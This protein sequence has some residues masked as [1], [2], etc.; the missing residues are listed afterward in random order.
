MPSLLLAQAYQRSYYGV[1]ILDGIVLHFYCINILRRCVKNVANK[2]AADG[3]LMRVALTPAE[4]TL[5]LAYHEF[6][7]FVIICLKVGA[8]LDSGECLVDDGQEHAH[9]SYLHDADVQKEE[10]GTEEAELDSK[11]DTVIVQFVS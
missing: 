1:C 4:H 10:D 2:L 3:L 9:K 5:E 11:R 6:N 7:K 8:G